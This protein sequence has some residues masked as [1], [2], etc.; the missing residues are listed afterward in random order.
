MHD[1]RIIVKITSRRIRVTSCKTFKN[2]IK[3]RVVNVID[4][5]VTKLS[6]NRIT[7]KNIMI[8]AYEKHQSEKKESNYTYLINGLPNPNKECLDIE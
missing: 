1:D 2:S 8:T 7:A 5:I 4:I 6:L 3:M